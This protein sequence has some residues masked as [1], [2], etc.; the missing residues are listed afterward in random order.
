MKKQAK[1]ILSVVILAISFFIVKNIFFDKSPKEHIFE[2]VNNNAQT[3]ISDIDRQ[4]FSESMAIRGIE[5]VS[6]IGESVDFYCGGKGIAPSSQDYGFYYTEDDLPKAIWC[7]VKYCDDSLLV[8]D[9][10]G[11]STDYQHNYYYTEKIR[12]NFYYYEA[13]F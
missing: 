5:D 8:E 13:Q 4:E 7:G 3:L 10:D 6:I 11:Y 2:M 1:A 9:G 12:D